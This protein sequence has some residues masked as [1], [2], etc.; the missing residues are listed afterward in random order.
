MTLRN[1]LGS[2]YL[3]GIIFYDFFPHTLPR[4]QPIFF[5]ETAHAF[6]SGSVA[7]V[8]LFLQFLLLQSFDYF[9]YKVTLNILLLKCYVSILQVS[10]YLRVSH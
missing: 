5:C 8:L 1:I 2:L 4:F 9:Y 3:S 7:L 6:F 10:V